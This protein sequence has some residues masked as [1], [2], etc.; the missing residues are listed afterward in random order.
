MSIPSASYSVTMRVAVGN[1]SL[2]G[3]VAT[4]VSDAGGVVTALDVV[5]PDGKHMVIDITCNAVDD[6]HAELLK[7]ADQKLFNKF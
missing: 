3:S 6:G 7:A 1:A 2:I 4:A 5:E